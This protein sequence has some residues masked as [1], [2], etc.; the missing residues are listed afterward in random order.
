MQVLPAS[1]RGG[2]AQPKNVRGSWEG[3]ITHLY[4]YYTLIHTTYLIIEST[5]SILYIYKNQKKLSKKN[6]EKTN[7]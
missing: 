5:L 7:I 4:T 3:P 6:L 1:Y 2:V